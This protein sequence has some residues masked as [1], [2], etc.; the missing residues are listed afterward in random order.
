MEKALENQIGFLKVPK[1]QLIQLELKCTKNAFKHGT[2]GNR[3]KTPAIEEIK[4]SIT[5]VAEVGEI[6]NSRSNTKQR[7]NHF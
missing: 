3:K 1:L 6:F 5:N 2:E 4:I 7:R